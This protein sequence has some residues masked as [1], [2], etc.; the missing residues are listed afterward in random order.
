MNG[1]ICYFC[2]EF[3]E[4]HNSSG[5]PQFIKKE[6]GIWFCTEHHSS[7]IPLTKECHLFGENY[8]KT[9]ILKECPVCFVESHLIKLPTCTHELCLN[10]CKTNYFGSSN[11]PR[12][13]CDNQYA[14]IINNFNPVVYPENLTE[15]QIDYYEANKP[16][17]TMSNDD[18]TLAE[19]K[20]I[21][22]TFKRNRPEWMNTEDFINFE[23]KDIEFL[24]T[25]ELTENCFN[26]YKSN[27]TVS[28]NQCC[29][30]CRAEP[31]WSKHAY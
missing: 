23:N 2:E 12:P 18:T 19:I 24:L 17:Y 5:N 27:M 15:E 14:S 31:P 22:D 26:E 16:N 7:T 6:N 9:S 8:D 1:Q 28:D 4:F 30:L 13:I 21:R 3:Q 11:N 20:T 25:L 10:C 29:P